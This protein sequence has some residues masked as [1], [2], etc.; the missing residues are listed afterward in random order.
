[1][2]VYS[3]DFRAIYNKKE[4]KARKEETSG[5]SQATINAL[6]FDVKSDVLAQIAK[7]GKIL[8]QFPR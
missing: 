2:K 1:M 4:K 3:P 8:F 5:S 6:V 7:M